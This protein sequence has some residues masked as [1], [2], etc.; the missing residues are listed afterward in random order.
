MKMPFMKAI[1][2]ARNKT[3]FHTNKEM[4]PKITETTLAIAY[5]QKP[6]ETIK[7]FFVPSL[8]FITLGNSA[9]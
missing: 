5:I 8:N 7:P 4:T 1:E 3:N 6:I 2:Y 9:L